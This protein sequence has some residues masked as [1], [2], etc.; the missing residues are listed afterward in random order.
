[1]DKDI[2]KKLS[3]IET[4]ALILMVFNSL[5]FIVTNIFITVWAK[6]ILKAL[7]Y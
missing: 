3:D 4:A 2:K 5:F 6:L 1:M 7:G